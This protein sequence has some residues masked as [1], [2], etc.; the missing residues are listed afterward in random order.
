MPVATVS[1]QQ[2]ALV[3]VWEEIQ[4]LLREHWAQVW[5]DH[6]RLPL[7]IHK[8]AYDLLELS[9][10]LVVVTMRVEEELQGYV[11]AMLAHHL[12]S[13]E[14][15]CAHIDLWYVVQHARQG[16]AGVWLLKRAIQ[17]LRDKG[18]QRISIGI[19]PQAGLASVL[20]RLGAEPI[21][22]VWALWTD[23]DTPA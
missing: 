14:V 5:L 16:L 15:L 3:V 1:Y 6:A 20:R 19:P 12:H 13:C 2:E 17:V 9:G 11:V 7:V 10:R 23:E 4:A 21:E 8:E 22:T 18:V